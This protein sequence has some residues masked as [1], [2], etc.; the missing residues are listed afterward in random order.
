MN[1]HELPSGNLLIP[2]HPKAPGPAGDE[3]EE[4]SPDHPE[5]YYWHELA[6]NEA[7]YGAWQRV[8][9]LEEVETA[10]RAVDRFEAGIG[11]DPKGAK[12]ADVTIAREMLKMRRKS[13][14]RCGEDE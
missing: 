4:I 2:K 6:T 5:W 10:E 7:V 1:A 9:T 8:A 14:E 3:A 12:A 13:I 11:N